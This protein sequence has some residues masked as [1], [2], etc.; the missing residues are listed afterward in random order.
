MFYHVLCAFLQSECFLLDSRFPPMPMCARRQGKC[1]GVH[2]SHKMSMLG[3]HF[4]APVHTGARA[5]S[6]A[7][8]LGVLQCHA[9]LTILNYYIR[10]NDI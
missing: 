5:G 1:S 8:V 6:R 2:D 7:G 3:A 4:V 9:E 10:I